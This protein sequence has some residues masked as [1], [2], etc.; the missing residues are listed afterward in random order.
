MPPT[1]PGRFGWLGAIVVLVSGITAQV[2]LYFL[3]HDTAFWDRMLLAVSVGLL[4]GMAFAQ[5]LRTLRRQ[6]DWRLVRHLPA[7]IQMER[8]DD[9]RIVAFVETLDGEPLVLTL[10]EGYD[11]REDNGRHLLELLTD[12]LPDGQ[13]PLGGGS[14]SGDSE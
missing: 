11:P 14:W 12:P 6:R 10:P 5:F 2:A 1:P 9:G 4:A 13:K 8:Q 7:K 3:P